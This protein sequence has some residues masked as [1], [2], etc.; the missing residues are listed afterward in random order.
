MKLWVT[1]AWKDNEEGNFDYL[2]QELNKYGIPTEYDKV[3]IIPGQRLWSQI[4]DKINSIDTTGW[5]YLITPNSLHS[6]PCLEELYLALDRA[7]ETKSKNFP[8]IGLVTN[9]VSFNDVPSPL[10][11][12]LCV[13]LAIPNWKEQIKDGLLMQ[14]NK[15]IDTP[16]TR[17]IYTI[18]Q[19]FN[20]TGITTTIEIRPRFEELHFWRIAV[21]ATSNI[22]EF[23]VGPTNTK[24]ITGNLENYIKGKLRQLI[25]GVD[26]NFVGAG[27]KLTPGTSAYIFIDNEAPNFVAF[28]LAN[29][30]Y[31]M[32]TQ[33]EILMLK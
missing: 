20:G 21:P 13:S 15:R 30:A 24:H 6:E 12:R 17:F 11:I 8:M 33:M 29:D 25:N 23:G 1:Y 27:T 28:G 2:I 5:A 32:P 19:D 22:V 9:G 10:K 3:A 7:L 16:Q 14:P 4:A 26:C 31:S 18:S